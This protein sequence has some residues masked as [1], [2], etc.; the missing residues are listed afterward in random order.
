M[1]SGT[2]SRPEEATSAADL[3]ASLERDGIDFRL[4]AASEITDAIAEEMLAVFRASFRTWPFLDP[5]VPAIDHLRWKISGPAS[6]LASFQGRIGGRLALATTAFAGWMLV[7]GK[8]Q[9][10]LVFTDHAV[11]PDFQGRG[12]YSRAVAY[13]QQVLRYRSD[14]AMH[15]R[16]ASSR[17]GG[18]IANI[19]GHT[20]LGNR[21]TAL[22]RVIARR[23]GSSAGAARTL[24]PRGVDRF[25]PRF[26]A[27]FAAAADSFDG[28]SEGTSEFLSWRYGDRRGGKREVLVV[29]Q[30]GDGRLLGYAVVRVAGRVG[31]LIDLL[32]LP[33]RPDAVEALVRSAVELAAA[34][35]AMVVKCWLPRRHPY[36]RQLRRAGFFDSR[37]D[38]GVGY[39]AVEAS[40]D[41][42]LPLTDPRARIH[43]T[44][45]DTDLV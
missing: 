27:L 29:E 22:W 24:R 37:R 1:S 6:P 28:I 18:P 26:D 31:Y 3:L 43:F 33:E 5:G 9:L 7:A 30:P 16:S 8:R 4:L 39:H 14:F 32:A 25:D 41:D 12:L 21:V 36:R 19:A 20:P 13:R 10:R 44:L 23:S 40:P 34:S 35:G 15:E 11:H 2:P 17:I 38:A 45:G 42:L